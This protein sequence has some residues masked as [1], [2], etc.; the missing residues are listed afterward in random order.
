MTSRLWTTRLQ[1]NLLRVGETGFGR[2]KQ[3]AL[4]PAPINPNQLS[5]NDRATNRA[6]DHPTNTPEFRI[7]LSQGLWPRLEGER[8]AHDLAVA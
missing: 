4:P 6:R 7:G 1:M 8:H 2:F 5:P 3:E